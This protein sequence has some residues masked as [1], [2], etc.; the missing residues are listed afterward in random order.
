M[1]TGGSIT[2]IIAVGFLADMIGLQG[3]L[4]AAVAFS[5]LALPAILLLPNRIDRRPVAARH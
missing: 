4:L 5:G 2:S 1:M 3:A